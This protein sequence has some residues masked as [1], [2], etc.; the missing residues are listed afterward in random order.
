MSRISTGHLEF[1]RNP[2]SRYLYSIGPSKH[3]GI[4]IFASRDI[5][6][7][8]RISIFLWRR[9]GSPIGYIRDES[10]RFC[11]HKKEPNALILQDG[12]HFGLHSNRDIQKNEEI[13]IN[14][15]HAVTV[16]LSRG[17]FELPNMVR[18][19][20][21]EYIKYTKSPKGRSLADELKEILEGKWK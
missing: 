15:M 16:M 5:P 3:H 2:D 13:F 8:E 7:G 1:I 10:C 11:N 19:R 9:P 4:G 21:K 17:L 20:T 12:H 6:A 18:C 14:Y